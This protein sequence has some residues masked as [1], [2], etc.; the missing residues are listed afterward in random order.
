MAEDRS[1]EGAVFDAGRRLIGGVAIGGALLGWFTI[2]AYVIATGGDLDALSRPATALTLAPAA[3]RWFLASMLAD[4]FG[5]Y[6]PFLAVGGYLWGRL[7]PRF[8]APIDI[9][10]LCLAGYAFLGRAGTSIQ[11]AALPPLADAHAA[12]DAMARTSSKTAW[13]AVVNAAQGGLWR[14]EGPLTVCWGIVVGRALWATGDRLGVLLMACGGLF[15][16]VFVAGIA[17]FAE[18]GQVLELATLVL[19]PLWALLAGLKLLRR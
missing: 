14:M 19:L 4:S 1:E 8:G 3:Q 15:G 10:T 18:A 13:L 9:A 11:I 7:R 2:V 5:F 17:G 16:L 12:G 6:L